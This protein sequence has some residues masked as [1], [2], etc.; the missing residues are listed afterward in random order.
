VGAAGRAG[1]AW[2][3]GIWRFLAPITALLA[4]TGVVAAVLA[5]VSWFVVATGLCIVLVLLVIEGAYR[6]WLD[7]LPPPVSLVL[8]TLE[9]LHNEGQTLKQWLLQKFTDNQLEAPGGVVH[10]DDWTGKVV[11]ALRPLRPG[12]AYR[13]EHEDAAQVMTAFAGTSPGESNVLNILTARLS[14]LQA[15][16]ADLKAGPT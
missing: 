7:A 4:L 9:T 3:A 5:K 11:S 1:Y 8:P 16:I 13:V 15:V 14:R 6:L 10:L 12:D 2:F